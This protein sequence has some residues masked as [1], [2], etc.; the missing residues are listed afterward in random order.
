MKMKIDIVKWSSRLI[1]FAVCVYQMYSLME[2]WLQ[3]CTTKV[4]TAG[5][6]HGQNRLPLVTIC[7]QLTDL[8]RDGFCGPDGSRFLVLDLRYR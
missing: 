6:Y 4:S 5:Y 3:S 8:M 7:A 1:C 2:S